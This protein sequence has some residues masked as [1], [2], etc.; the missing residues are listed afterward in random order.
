LRTLALSCFL[1]ITSALCAQ[2]SKPIA[3]D[4]SL[5]DLQGRKLAVADY[6]GKVILLD[7]W[8]SWCVPC[9]KEIPRFIEWQKKYSGEGFQVIGISMD[10]D[11]KAARTF[12]KRYKFNYPIAIGTERLA[13]SYGGILGLPANL[14]INRDGQIVAKVVGETDLGKL[15]AEI[16]SQLAQKRR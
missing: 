6:T 2:Q 9:Q 5:T 10:D 8:A 3:P 1:L 11:E 12:A 15:E 14:I 4:F 13:E 7:F 16:K